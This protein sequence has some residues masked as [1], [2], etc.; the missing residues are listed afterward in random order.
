VGAPKYALFGQTPAEFQQAMFHSATQSVRAAAT[1]LHNPD[2]CGD[3]LSLID[4]L[5]K[6]AAGAR[7]IKVPALEACGANDALYAPFGCEAQL[8]RFKSKDKRTLIVKNAGHALPLE[9]TARTFRRKVGSWL[10][11]RGF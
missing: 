2:P 5:N 11:R 9:A 6:Q 3:N 10:S 4:A 1:P 7:T 8:E